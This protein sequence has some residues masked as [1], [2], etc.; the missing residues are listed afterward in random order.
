MRRIISRKTLFLG[1]LLLWGIGGNGYAEAAE[2]SQYA[3]P[4]LLPD[5]CNTPDGLE[6]LPDGSLLLSAPNFTDDSVPGAI[7]RVTPDN[8]VETYYHPARHPVSKKVYPMGIRAAE[9]GDLYVADC[10]ALTIPTGGSRLLRVVVRDGKPT[11]TVVVA[12]KLNMANGVAIRDG[13][14][15]L[16]DSNIGMRDERTL[17]AVFRFRLDEQNV[18]MQHPLSDDP[19]CIAVLETENPKIAVGADGIAFDSHGNLFV[20]NCGDAFLLKFTLDDNGKIISSQKFA[21]DPRMKSADGLYCDPRSDTIY[22]ADILDNAIFAVTPRGDVQLVCANG[23]CHGANGTLDA[24]S[25]AIVRN[26]Q[27]IIANF[28]RV[29]P[30][31]VNTASEK[32]YTLSVFP[33]NKE[34]QSE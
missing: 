28:D 10:Q 23:D 20:S 17:S 16:T 26:S 5:S 33:L 19:H 1:C 27:L 18:Q 11:K 4:I 7:L 14:V 12:E 22:V 15:Y 32:P 2:P 29:F 9:N 34:N 6:L 21:Q 31:S 8:Q 25:E 30:G 13:Y 3:P 24:P